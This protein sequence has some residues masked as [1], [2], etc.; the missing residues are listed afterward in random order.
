MFFN[1]RKGYVIMVLI[2]YQH[3]GSTSLEYRTIDKRKASSNVLCS[4]PSSEPFRFRVYL[5]LSV[6]LQV[7]EQGNIT[8]MSEDTAQ[9]DLGFADMD[10]LCGLV[11]RVHGYRPEI[12][13]RFPVLSDCLSSSGS[14]TGSTQSHVYNWG[15]AWKKKQQL[16][17]RKQRLR[18]QGICRA[19]NT[20]PQYP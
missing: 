14:G 11:V 15:D 9:K 3:A 2:N 13:V 10:H 12:R 17:S 19:D 18:P 6:H 4:R 1:T 8:H 5:S 20:R 7:S 16:R